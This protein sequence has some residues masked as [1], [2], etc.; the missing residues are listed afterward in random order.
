MLLFWSRWWMTMRGFSNWDGQLSI[1]S[2]P[3][4]PH[5]REGAFDNS[6]KPVSKSQPTPTHASHSSTTIISSQQSDEQESDCYIIDPKP[7]KIRG[8]RIHTRPSIEMKVCLCFPPTTFTSIK[9]T[10]PQRMSSVDVLPAIYHPP[11]LDPQIQDMYEPSV[12]VSA[13]SRKR[14]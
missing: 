12:T 1:S 11:V 4:L 5:S 7:Q 9:F 8:P 13:S 3:S 14:K 10:P 6:R 2:S